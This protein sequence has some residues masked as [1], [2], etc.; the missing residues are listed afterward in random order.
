MPADIRRALKKPISAPLF[1]LCPKAGRAHQIP[2]VSVWLGKLTPLP[3][4]DVSVTSRARM[5]SPGT[6]PRYSAIRCHHHTLPDRPRTLT[7]REEVEMIRPP[8]V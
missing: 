5:F 4:P 8:L 1:R 6:L 7:E 3:D 2:G